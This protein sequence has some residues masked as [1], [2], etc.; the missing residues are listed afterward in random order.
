M[1]S[2]LKI[3]GPD[4]VSFLQGYLTNDLDSIQPKIGHPMAITNIQGRVLANGWSYGTEQEVNLVIHATVETVVR[5]HLG[6]YMVFA[7]S[8]LNGSARTVYLND[9]PTEQGIELVPFGWH[10]HTDSSA[11]KDVNQL[12]VESEFPLITQPTSGQFL[13]Q[14]LCLTDHGAV[15]FTKGCYLGQEIVARAEH[16]GTVKR[17]LRTLEMSAESVEIGSK[18]C[19]QAGKKC[20]V[21]ARFQNQVLVV[22]QV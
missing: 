17:R 2:L 7:K 5:E 18:I 14:M 12:S 8:T 9:T 19:D 4:A 15:S 3:A 10:L 11:A 13:P 1:L 16:R 21:I 20:T 6:K 22:G